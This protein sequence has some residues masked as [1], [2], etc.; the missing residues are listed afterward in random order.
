[1]PPAVE[2]IAERVELA[3]VALFEGL[4]ADD[5]W[6]PYDAV[7]RVEGF[8]QEYFETPREQIMMIRAPTQEY[9][10]QV[11]QVVSAKLEIFLL[12]CR[13]QK[14]RNVK[15]WDRSG[16]FVLDGTIQNRI[17]RD[18]EIAIRS[19][20]TLGGLTTNLE[21]THSNKD[22]FVEGWACVEFR[23]TASLNY[24]RSKA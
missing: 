15:P 10:E 14:S 5:D 17:K 2:P 18:T 23:V 9:L 1:M 24:H 13:L 12:S 21:L 6:Y 3:L 8:W 19:N 4:D 20:V 11:S 16:T 7:W 22:I